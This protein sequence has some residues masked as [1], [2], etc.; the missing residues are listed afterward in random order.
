MAAIARRRTALK[1]KL[2]DY[3]A[4]PACGDSLAISGGASG[5][6]D[7]DIIDGVLGCT[8]CAA[9]Y[10]VVG[11]IPRFAVAAEG[12]ASAITERTRRTYT[13]SWGRFGEPA[14]AA[15]WEKDSYRYSELIPAD[16]TSGP[17]RL[18]LDAGC[19]AGHDLVRIADGGAEIIGFDLSDGVEVARRLT[20]HRPNVHVVQGDL[21]HLPFRPEIFD[22]VY[23]FG[24]LHHLS[25]PFRG[26]RNLARTLKPGAALITYLY[27]DFSDR[28]RLERALI[29]LVRA[30]RRVTSHLPAGVLYG[31]CWVGAPFVWAACAS[32]ARLLRSVAPRLAV[33]IPF[34]HTLRWNVLASDLFDRFAPPVEWR[35]SR[36]GVIAL[37]QAAGLDDVETR[38]FRGWVSWGRRRVPVPAGPA[39]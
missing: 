25:E 13:F 36:D 9:S 22:F 20:V 8:G 38:R 7:T 6:G 2:L 1:R 23:S 34:R 10:P 29:A 30:I 32:P 27:E 16:L 17:G 3:L 28:S 15:S 4:C 14:V 26:F 24:V 39:S 12:E 37:Y 31:L 5:T 35:Y 18:G 33:R 19:G 21:N 11:G